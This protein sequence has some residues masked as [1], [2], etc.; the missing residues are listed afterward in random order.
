[1]SNTSKPIKL[2]L[3]IKNVNSIIPIM[4]TKI[5]GILKKYF[6]IVNIIILLLLIFFIV[7]VYNKIKRGEVKEHYLTYFLPYYQDD[8]Q[9]LGI[10]YENNDTNKNYFKQKFLYKHIV[11]PYN[12]YN[13]GYVE[14]LIKEIIS[15]SFIQ[16]I[17]TYEIVDV[18]K[19]I[20]DLNNNSIQFLIMSVP[21]IIAVE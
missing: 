8:I 16:N 6:N 13:K 4:P 10:M 17:D 15:K 11:F 21:L 5:R 12:H 2:G 18:L 20:N 19:T 7:L 9:D 14:L 3:N 1:M